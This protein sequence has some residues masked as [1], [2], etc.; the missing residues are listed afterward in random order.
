MTR[1]TF[2]LLLCIFFTFVAFL[3][4]CST[5]SFT[6]FAMC[7][8]LGTMFIFLAVWIVAAMARGEV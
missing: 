4:M 2:Y 1:A 3:G 6:L 8:I 7:S 5:A